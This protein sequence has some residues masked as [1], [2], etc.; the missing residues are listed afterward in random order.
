MNGWGR[1]DSAS[2]FSVRRSFDE[3]SE[4]RSIVSMMKKILE[5]TVLIMRLRVLEEWNLLWRIKIIKTRQLSLGSDLSANWAALS[6]FYSPYYGVLFSVFF[7]FFWDETQ[8]WRDQLI[9]TMICM[10][11]T[12]LTQWISFLNRIIGI[13]IIWILV[14]LTLL[15]SLSVIYLKRNIL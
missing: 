12:A 13:E 3:N 14:S 4:L 8:T 6:A 1:F 11:Q 7:F 9:S 15:S 2:Q 5:W 10:L